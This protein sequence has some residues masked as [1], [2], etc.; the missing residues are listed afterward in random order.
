M[1]A[2]VTVSHAMVLHVTDAAPKQPLVVL[3]LLLVSLRSGSTLSCQFNLS[4]GMVKL[5]L[6]DA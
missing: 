6:E 5:T 4:H 3:G 2:E 1:D